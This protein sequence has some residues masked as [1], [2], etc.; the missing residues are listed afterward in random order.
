MLQNLRDNSKGVISYILIAFLVIIMALFGMESL[1]N[2][3][4]SADKAGAVNG[5]RIS[6]VEVETAIQ[7]KRQEL[8]NRFGENLPESM[9]STEALSNSVMDELIASKALAQ[10]AKNSGMTV[11]TQS[12][13][14]E[15]A[16]TS[17]FQDESGRFSNE[18][19]LQA[20]SRAGYTPSTY[21]E[22]SKSDAVLGQLY[23]GIVASNFISATELDEFIQLS[24]E[25]RNVSFFTLSSERVGAEVEISE[26]K[27]EDFYN[28][29]AEMFT[30]PEQVAVDYIELNT[31]DLASQITV[32][33]EQ[34]RKQ[35]ELNQSNAVAAKE[36][37]VA[38][39]L[40]E[41]NDSDK[42][43]AVS[44]K[45]SEG[46]D[47]AELAK[48]YSDDFGSRDTGG[49]LGFTT[50]SGL[51]AEFVAAM[52]TLSVGSVSPAVK[53]EAGTHFI[54]VI[55]VKDTTLKFEDVRADIA[56]SLKQTEAEGLFLTKLEQL[57]DLSFNADNLKDVAQELGLKVANTGFF[58]KQGGS[59]IA[60]N[61]AVIEASFS[62][63]VFAAG[64][65]S[66]AIELS[67]T[68]VVVVKKTGEEPSYVLPLAEVREQI[69]N[70]LT[71]ERAQELI[72]EQ[73]LQL[74]SD[75]KS[76][77]AITEVAETV[78]AELKLVDSLTRNDT[79]AGA[80]VVNFAFSLPKPT[81]GPVVSGLLTRNGD[82]LVLAVNSIGAGEE[83]M[84][85]EEKQM[86]SSQ[87]AIILGQTDFAS[88]QNYLVNIADV[89]RK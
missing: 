37:H 70:R 7:R 69:K 32:T 3:N 44:Q 77:K 22:A 31:A 72:T 71:L 74:V 8:I 82:Y 88:F 36:R 51:P 20:I 15:I 14:N 40:I 34:V 63:D 4:P 17:A 85:A 12:I 28:Q 80:E 10:A 35:F 6:T 84:T 78:E 50:G 30:K 26:T 47:F 73:G 45:L 11:S 59:G 67:P 61:K 1:F 66:E 33:D 18:L 57:R 16:K 60:A 53:S 2:W 54:K 42:I 24:N 27:I 5:E 75:I 55:D 48:T 56:D 68:H 83:N 13:H 64:N 49:D 58:T 21:I 41:D 38:H 76:G 89:E 65:S 19:F 81:E 39:I 79:D 62:E 29:N 25:T 46:V 23:T 52:N 86:L 87:L 43:N 9:L